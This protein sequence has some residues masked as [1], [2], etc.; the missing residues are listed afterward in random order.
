MELQKAAKSL[1]SKWWLPLNLAGAV[2]DQQALFLENRRLIDQMFHYNLLNV[3]HLPHMLRATAEHKHEYSKMMRV[4]ASREILS[5]SNMF[6]TFNRIA[7][8]FRAIDFLAPIAG[9]T[10]LPVHLDSHRFPQTDNLLA[11]QCL[12]DRAMI[13]Q[14]RENM[15]GVG[16]LNSD[17]L[18]AQSATFYGG[19]R[20][21]KPKWRKEIQTLP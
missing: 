11:H 6:R 18:S 12:S 7:S 21:S 14:V 16:R 15:V 1:P 20:S 3:L 13:E 5:R 17:V 2:K 4:N 10:L 9:M 8:S 19:Y